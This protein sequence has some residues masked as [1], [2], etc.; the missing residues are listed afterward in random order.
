MVLINHGFDGNER[1]FRLINSNLS[2][3]YP[4]KYY[5]AFYGDKLTKGNTFEWGG[6]GAT[7]ASDEF[8]EQ[9]NKIVDVAEEHFGFIMK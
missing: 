8:R 9:R 2:S 1:M 5:C 3:L 6:F 7:C 4:N